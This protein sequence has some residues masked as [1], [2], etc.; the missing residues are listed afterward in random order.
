MYGFGHRFFTP[1]RESHLHWGSEM[2]PLL[3][4]T[5]ETRDDAWPPSQGSV[6]PPS[7][8]AV[9]DLRLLLLVVAVAEPEEVP[10]HGRDAAQAGP[11][12][13]LLRLGHLE[14]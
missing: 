8:D 2:G 10:G 9:G 11:L 3:R 1:A 7:A 4:V 6:P 12:C 14:S 5:G 13:P